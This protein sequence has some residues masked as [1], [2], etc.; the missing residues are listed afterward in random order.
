M[1]NELR[2]TNPEVINYLKKCGKE[3]ETDDNEPW[4][5]ERW[6]QTFDTGARWGLI[7]SNESESFN[8][9]YKVERRLPVVGLV[10]GTWY[11]VVQWFNEKK[12]IALQRQADGQRWPKEVQLKM[13][14]HTIKAVPMTVVTIDVER[15]EFEVHMPYEKDFS[16]KTWKYKVL[17]KHDYQPEDPQLPSRRVTCEC[18]KPQLTGI[19]CAHV[20]AVCGRYRWEVDDFVDEW[21]STE[22]ML[23]I[24][25][26]SDF[27]CYGDE[28]NWPRYDGPVVFPDRNMINRGRRKKDCNWMWMDAMRKNKNKIRRTRANNNPRQPMSMEDFNLVAVPTHGGREVQGTYLLLLRETKVKLPVAETRLN[29]AVIPLVSILELRVVLILQEKELNHAEILLA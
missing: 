17:I 15:G 29:Q 21:Y 7:S 28:E 19:P 16:E 4:R 25:S 9:R 24:W 3:N 6:A 1:W 23:K 12:Q 18:K 8:S 27:H 14:K 10:E 5:P 22:N 2:V 20:V 13:M 26:S 11:K